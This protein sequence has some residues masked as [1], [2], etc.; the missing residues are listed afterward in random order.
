MWYDSAMNFWLILLGALALFLL[1]GFQYHKTDI[2]K[3]TLKT[4]RIT[5]PVRICVL[6][7]LHCR[8]FGEKQSRITKAVEE[9][10][11][12][13]ILFPG[14]LFDV[15]RDHE[16]VFELIDQLP[17]RWM[18]Y[19]SGNHEI[20]LPE[21][22]ELRKRMEAEGV[23]VLEDA[24][25]EFSDEIEVIGLTDRHRNVGISKEV[26]DRQKQTD[27]YHILISHRPDYEYV[28]RTLDCDL[29]ICGHNHGGQ[30]RIPF[31]HIGMFGPH[32]TLFPKYTEG[33]HD[34]DGRL[35]FVSRGLAS[36]D[37]RFFRLYNNPEVAFIDLVPKEK[38]PSGDGSKE[39]DF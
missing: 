8:R 5:K 19:A 9:Y 10:D 26:Y 23:H 18:A 35:M 12:D 24:G 1:C 37:P 13:M 25:I 29:I 14:D 2:T 11:P 7:D 30:W 15:D 4:D 3:I 22:S 31:T 34:L 17:G 21:I 38:D 16:I 36:G 39:V 33:L 32:R 28:Y 27:H 6:A 20:R